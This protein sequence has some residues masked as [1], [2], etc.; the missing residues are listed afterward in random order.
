ML[1]LSA[2]SVV[3]RAY[4]ALMEDC[5]GCL[6]AL[7]LRRDGGD[8]A[9]RGRLAERVAGLNQLRTQLA[10]QAEPVAVICAVLGLV[11]R[12]GSWLGLHP[13][14]LPTVGS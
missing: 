10:G 14:I 3:D 4:A 7:S 12:C 8:P 11:Q 2:Y 5:Q 9:C 1:R 6:L 13:G